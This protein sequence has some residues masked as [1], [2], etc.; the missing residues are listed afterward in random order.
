MRHVLDAVDARVH[1][2]EVLLLELEIILLEMILLEALLLEA[3]LLERVGLL[4]QLRARSRARNLV[5][6]HG[7]HRHLVHAA[8]QLVSLLLPNPSLLRQCMHLHRARQA[9][10]S[11]QHTV[12][13]CTGRS[14]GKCCL[15]R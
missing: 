10:R 8:V 5:R 13:G 7:H 9:P 14:K 2:L 3:P 6:V 4:Y 11:A 12:P 1:Q 15:Q